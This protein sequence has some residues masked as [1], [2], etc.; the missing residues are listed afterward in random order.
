MPIKKYSRQQ[1][2]ALTRSSSGRLSYLDR[3]G[4]VRPEKI[5][6][7]IKPAV[8]YTQEQI[9]QIQLLNQAFKFLHVNAIRMAIKANCL[10]KVVELLS[11]LLA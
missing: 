8:I 5:G 2:I 3:A 9:D 11:G 4:F 1:A 7:N 10:P 6:N